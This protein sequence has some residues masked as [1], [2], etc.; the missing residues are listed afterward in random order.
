ME[1]RDFTRRSL[2]ASQECVWHHKNTRNNDACVCAHMCEGTATQPAPPQ[3]PQSLDPI[4][5][6]FLFFFLNDLCI[7]LE[8]GETQMDTL[9]L[10]LYF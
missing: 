8:G 7:F 10:K 2:Q 4:A 6:F 3:Q 5:F 1:Y 9:K